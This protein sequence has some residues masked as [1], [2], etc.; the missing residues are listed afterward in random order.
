MVNSTIRKQTVVKQHRPASFYGMRAS[1]CVNYFHEVLSVTCPRRAQYDASYITVRVRDG[2]QCRCRMRTCN[3]SR[4]LHHA[5]EVYPLR[6]LSAHV[7]KD[8]YASFFL[9]ASK[10]GLDFSV[11]LEATHD[12]WPSLTPD[13]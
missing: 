5:E 13:S 1:N 2:S 12:A 6:K 8:N 10:S 3:T 7:A 9:A 4:K 11:R